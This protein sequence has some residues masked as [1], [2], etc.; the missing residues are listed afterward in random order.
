MDQK[1]SDVLT[2][3]HLIKSEG[4]KTRKELETK[5]VEGFAKQRNELE[6]KM[7][8]G[9]AKQKNELET[10]MVEGFAK[11]RKAITNE[12]KD[13]I[14]DKVETLRRNIVDDV[15][16]FQDAVITEVRE[17]KQETIVNASHR[18]IL[19]DHEIRL[20]KVESHLFSN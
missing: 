8:E 1:Q 10:K 11:Q 9:F 16:N 17:I 2:I 19:T 13:Y 20:T 5:M 15:Q 4:E 18:K 7:V 3:L 6:T 12:L 14:D